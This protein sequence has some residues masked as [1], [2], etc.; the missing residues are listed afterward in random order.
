MPDSARIPL[1]GYNVIEK[2]SAESMAELV[3]KWLDNPFSRSVLKF[4]T[5]RDTCGRRV[6]LALRKYAGEN[7]KLC[8]KCSTA[9]RMIARILNSILRK[10]RLDRGRIQVHL[11]DPM[12]RKGL[13][14]VL[15]GIAEYGISRPFTGFSPFL[16]VW[17]VTTVC[18]LGCVHCYES[19]RTR[20]PDEL[21]TDGAKLTVR[22]L[23]DA[24]VAYIAFSGGEPL[25]RTDLFEIMDE[26]KRNEMAFSIATNATLATPQISRR[27]KD[28]DCAFVQASL[29]GATA[30]THDTFRGTKCFERT[31]AGIRN[32]V[33]AS[34]PV[35]V[36][37]TVTKRN[38]HEVPAIIDMAEELG[39]MLFMSYNFIPTGRGAALKHADLTPAERE[40]LLTW[41]ASEIG[42]RK[43]NLLSTACQYSRIC[44]GAGRLSLTHFDTF[45]QYDNLAKSA[46]FLAEFVGGCGTSRLYCALE[47]NGDIEPCVF[48]PIVLGN[49][50]RDD[51]LDIWHNHPVFKAIRRRESFKGYCGVCEHRNICGGCRARA[52]GY[53]GDLTESDPGCILNERAWES[54]VRREIKPVQVKA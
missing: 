2:H 23:A 8:V 53:L 39:A 3:E 6:E 9:Y 26:V 13:A 10:G 34:I 16:T 33:A 27:L 25:M 15:E 21:N 20:A 38:L 45:G 24:G 41:M 31:V 50:L 46:Q 32:L 36:A 40:Q 30:E 44:A 48:I 19:A 35:G 18:N 54:V 51:F 42:K 29:D 1:A 49:I 43:L 22:R 4:C 12:W 17:N 14:S 47:P 11:R 28:L 37:T 7:V 5:G 52:Y